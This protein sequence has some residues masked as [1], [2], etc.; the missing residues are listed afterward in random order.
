MKRVTAVAIVALT[1]CLALAAGSPAQ[2]H[3]PASKISIRYGL[4]APGARVISN[5]FKGRV[6]SD[7]ARCE[8]GRTV[9]VFHKVPGP[10]ELIGTVLTD[11]QGIWAFGSD[12]AAGEHY[13]KVTPRRFD[14]GP[15]RYVCR[16][17]TS[18]TITVTHG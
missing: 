10:D 8:R 14:V 7:L 12:I 4:G 16:G 11:A 2:V 1:L 17:A 6:R 15:N 3:R 18:R 5:Y 13:A 9:K